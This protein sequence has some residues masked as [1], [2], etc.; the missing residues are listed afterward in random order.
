VTATVTFECDYCGA[1]QVEVLGSSPLGWWDV[2][3][4]GKD[5][6]T[7]HACSGC[8]TER[9]KVY[10]D[11]IARRDGETQRILGENPSVEVEDIPIH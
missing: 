8:M 6:G 3:G 2:P 11:V 1:T 10:D 7:G 5:G 4:K 9:P